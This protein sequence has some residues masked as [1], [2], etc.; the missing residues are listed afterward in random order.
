MRLSLGTEEPAQEDG[1]C[2]FCQERNVLTCHF[3]GENVSRGGRRAL[4]S[5]QRR[6]RIRVAF[7]H[8]QQPDDRG[9]GPYSPCFIFRERAWSATEQFPGL[10]LG[11]PELLSDRADLVRFDQRFS[12][13]HF[14]LVMVC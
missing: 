6:E 9:S 4:T 7:Q 3:E 5:C 10:Y 12:A 8:A 14:L 2:P 13:F 1:K 11:E